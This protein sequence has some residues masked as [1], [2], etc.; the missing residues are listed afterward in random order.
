[1][2]VLALQGSG[3]TAGASCQPDRQGSELYQFSP[4]GRHLRTLRTDTGSTVY[5]FAYDTAGRLSSVTDGDGN[6]TSFARD[7]TGAWT[8]IL[9]P[10]GQRTSV[11]VD[12]NG[13]LEA[14]TNPADE[15]VL[16]T[17]NADGL[18]A[19]FTDP[20]SGT[21]RF[22][23]DPLGRLVRH[24]DP[25]GAIKTLQRTDEVDGY[26][27]TYRDALERPTTYRV[28]RISEGGVRRTTTN[29]DDTQDVAERDTGGRLVVQAAD[30][31]RTEQVE[32]PDPRFGM[33]SPVITSHQ[34]TTPGGLVLTTTTARAAG[35]TD[36]ANP[37]SLATLTDTVSVNGRP[38]TRAYDA[39]T[40]TFTDTSAV[41]R[42][43]L[44]TIDA[45]GRVVSEKLGD[46]LA[47]RYSYDTRGRLESVRQSTGADERVTSLAYNPA[48]FLESVTDPL[49]RVVRYQYDLAGRVTKQTLPGS[50]DVEFGYDANSNRSSVT[51]PGRPAHGFGYTAFDLE[52]TYTPPS[53]GGGSTTVT[54]VYQADRQLDRIDLPT[55]QS[56]DI[57]FDAAGRLATVTLGR[58]AV[59][60]SYK[61]ATGQVA[62]ITAP[63]GIGLSYSYDGQLPTAESMSGPVSGDVSTAFDADFRPSS[64]TV[65]GT[66]AVALGYD[67]DSLLTTS[68]A[69][70][71]TRKPATGLVSGATIG[72]VSEQWAYTD[73]GEPGEY[74]VDQG[75]QELYRLVFLRDLLGRITDKTEIVDGIATTWSYRYDIAGRLDEVK[76]DDAVV[77][78][79]SYD[80]N[81]NRLSV[82]TPSGTVNGAYDNQD[83][84]T[85]YGPA[86]YEYNPLG[87]LVRKTSGGQATDYTYDEIGNLI[88]VVEP[89]GTT[90]EY[91][92]DGRNRRVGKKVNGVLV[93]GLLWEGQLRPV[94]ETDGAGNVV[95]RFVYGTRP[96]VPEY[97]IKGG[98]TYRIVTDHL[99]SPRLVVS[100][101]TGEVVQRMEQ[102]EWGNGTLDSNPGFQ[103]FGFAGGCGTR[104]QGWSASGPGTTTPKPGAGRR[105]TQSDLPVVTRT[106]LPSWETILST[107]LIRLDS[108]RIARA[109][110][111]CR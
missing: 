105:G 72:A 14:I 76:R 100:A 23:Y 49:R 20:R 87:Q 21:S 47:V 29:P 24:E 66:P 80:A 71:L 59:E 54:N 2:S 32:G 28:E 57:S 68:G 103:P 74:R 48:G 18:L 56:V 90:I 83:R 27:V 96:N 99:G 37:L 61:P 65:T 62:G 30:G 16:L 67:A 84:L 10:D 89:A 63:G 58:G 51:P 64:Q 46:L 34:T 13:H 35:L 5:S 108:L 106:C 36:S 38:S 17:A 97:M 75:G 26:T 3:A 4:S 6:V 79:Y 88:R 78:A 25:A 93:Q 15:S 82:T 95:S 9:S 8:G 12:G 81:G 98:I 70:G 111:S 7:A 85:T 31:T 104:R 50:R 101:T 94:A 73:F 44:T 102:D 53:V 92:V 40:R 39:A 77:S 110:G 69:L 109:L 52:E 1:M 22:A 19:S 91:L 42:T 55:G 107:Q 11:A 45:Q 86:S 43:R 33:T 60:Y 41:G